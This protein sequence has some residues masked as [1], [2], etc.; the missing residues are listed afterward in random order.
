[1]VFHFRCFPPL[2]E[3]DKVIKYE[4][5]TRT[6]SSSV[7]E[8]FYSALSVLIQSITNS[9]AK[10]STTSNFTQK[11]SN[12]GSTTSNFTQKPS[13]LRAFTL[14]ELN[15]ATQNFATTT[16]I[17]ENEFGSTYKGVVKS[18]EH[19]FD[20]IHVAVKSIRRS[21][22]DHKEWETQISVLGVTDHPNLLK[23]I[24]Y[25]GENNFLYL[26][27]EYMVNRSVRDHLSAKSETHLSWN[28][29]L[30]VAQDVACGLAY[31]HEDTDFQIISKVLKSS[32]ILLDDQW[33]AKL[34]D[35]GVSQILD[36]YGRDASHHT[37]KV[38][39]PIEYTAPEFIQTGHLTSMSDVWSYGVFLYELITGK[40]PLHR[41]LPKNKQSLLEWV[42]GYLESKRFNQIVD[43]RLLEG[44]SPLESVKKL[45][46]IADKCLS[47]NPRRRP[48]MSK[49]L[50][51]VN[52][53]IQVP[54]Q[55]TSLA[56]PQVPSQAT[57]LASP[58]V[59]PQAISSAS[60]LVPSQASSPASH[61]V[62]QVVL[63]PNKAFEG[64]THGGNTNENT[65]QEGQKCSMRIKLKKPAC[66]PQIRPL[67]IL[68]SCSK[69]GF[70]VSLH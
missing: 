39:G 15:A 47:A 56:S 68:K 34:S 14:A 25:C 4:T 32:N 63:D 41:K 31:I 53:L 48:K 9:G 69:K 8:T 43:P 59:P 46:V 29:R 67:K 70:C 57:S 26:V 7:A 33:N 64:S 37:T 19:P 2:L 40:P 55:A 61:Q 16:R 50:E 66:L 28:M 21:L 65:K 42:K 12:L 5:T 13:N 45:S 58:R 51:M 52:Q 18:L 30:K 1:M 35:Y 11:R 60:S 49:V 27:Y 3:E 62:P 17:S 20:A 6:K 23:L 10:S 22:Q 24:G 36:I 38:A 44:N 54:S